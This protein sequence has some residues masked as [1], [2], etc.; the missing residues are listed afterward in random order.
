[1]GV[2]HEPVETCVAE[3]C[4]LDDFAGGGEL[5]DACG[6]F[7]YLVVVEAEVEVELDDVDVGDGSIAA[8]E[9]EIEAFAAWQSALEEGL[10]VA[11]VVGV[12]EV[13]VVDGLPDLGGQGDADVGCDGSAAVGGLCTYA[14]GDGEPLHG[15]GLG[16]LVV[17]VFGTD[18]GVVVVVGR[19]HSVEGI[20]AELK[21][22]EG[23]ADIVVDVESEVGAG[24]LVVDDVGGEAEGL[25]AVELGEEVALDFGLGFGVGISSEIGSGG[26][27]QHVVA[28]G[29]GTGLDV[30]GLVV[31][32]DEVGGGHEVDAEHVGAVVT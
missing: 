30:V 16:C 20:D 11:E 3:S 9:L 29:V 13:V 14:T 5:D 8:F 28:Y 2:G 25:G 26:S 17:V 12:A 24:D 19:H 18:V 23:V 4:G 32:R 21:G 22:G 10:C 31:F 15:Q 7:L 1:M 6:V 27:C